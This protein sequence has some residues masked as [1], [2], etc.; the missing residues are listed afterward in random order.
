MS[1][2]TTYGTIPTTSSPPHGPTSAGFDY[3]SSARQR[4]RAGVDNHRPWKM[5]FE[6]RSLGLPS[7]LSDTISRIQANNAYFQLNYAIIVFFI[8]CWSL[9]WHPILFVGLM[10]TWLFFFF[11]REEPVVIHGR[12]IDDRPVLLVMVVFTLVLLLLT[13][14]TLN[15]VVAIYIGL[16]FAVVHAVP[17]E[18]R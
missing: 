9:I 18:D 16:V 12:P 17:E 10:Y 1:T 13:D 5:M 2:T 11:R 7:S 3:I 15:I 14:V 6:F 4:I 8:L